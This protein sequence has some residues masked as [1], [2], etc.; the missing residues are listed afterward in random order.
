[1]AKKHLVK[2]TYYDFLKLLWAVVIF[3]LAFM[4]WV[5]EWWEPSSII[6]RDYYEEFSGGDSLD[7]SI[8]SDEEHGAALDKSTAQKLASVCALHQDWCNKIVWSGYFSDY[9]KIW[10]VSQ[11]FVIFNF[12]DRGITE[13]S[14]IKK[15]FKTL[16]INSNAG[17]RRWGATWTKITINLDSFTDISQFWQV[18]T[19]EFWHIVDLWV[20]NGNSLSKNSNFTEFWKVKFSVDDPSLEYYKYSWTSEDIRKSTAQ[21]KDFCSQYWMSNPFEDFAEC[22]NLYLNN[23]KLFRTMAAESPIL[24]NKFN[25]FANLFGYQIL[26]DNSTEFPY[27]WWRPWD[28][29]VLI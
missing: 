28:T 15:Q 4:I 16:V 2:I 22:H 19:H 17:K 1:M 25:F 23:R 7:K 14:D 29:T 21:E 13:G 18:L 9:D 6:E 26:W 12:L 8:S 3:F 10:Y 5:K 20:L 11:Y 24:K 27:N